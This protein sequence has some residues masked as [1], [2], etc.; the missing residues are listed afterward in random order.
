MREGGQKPPLP[1][2]LVDEEKKMHLMVH[3]DRQADR[4]SESKTESAQ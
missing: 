4:H 1:E 2:R 3:T